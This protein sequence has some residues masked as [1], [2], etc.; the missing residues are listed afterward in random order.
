[1]NKILILFLAYITITLN[2]QGQL[3]YQ[4]DFSKILKE[5][6]KTNSPINFNLLLNRF[7]DNDSTLENSDLIALQ[8]GYTSS[9]NYNPY[10]ELE[11]E[12]GIFQLNHSSKY[13]ASLELAN[14]FQKRNPISLMLN[15]EKSY[16]L[17]KLGMID[18]SQIYYS[19]FRK[20]CESILSSGDGTNSSPYFVL[21]PIDGQIIIERYWGN[22]I[23]ELGTGQDKYQNLLDVLTMEDKETKKVTTFYFLIEHATE[24]M[25]K[26]RELEDIRRKSIR[27]K[28]KD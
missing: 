9:P 13:R 11:I 17:H 16:S 7:L 12:R 14:S 5:S 28:Q 4:K 24:T 27:K 23:T 20:L 15:L 18:S 8:I 26:V 2:A 3:N 1:M 19:R 22:I 6:K 21:G 25:F 10:R